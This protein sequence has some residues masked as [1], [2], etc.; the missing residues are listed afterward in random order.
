MSERLNATRT[1]LAAL[2][3]L[4][5][6]PAFELF[7]PDYVHHSNALGLEIHGHQDARDRLLPML[8]QIGL[9]QRLDQ[10]IESD[11][12]VIATMKATSNIR[13]GENTIVYV[14]RFDGE[15]IVEVWGLSNPVAR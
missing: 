5:Y 14:C 2:E 15:K 8:E 6:A 9:R 4:D 11:N 13:E 10:I 12:F 1:A 7:A 3:Q